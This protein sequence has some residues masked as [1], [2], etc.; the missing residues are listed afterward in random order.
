MR[1]VQN[2]GST[3]NSETSDYPSDN[4]DSSPPR[5]ILNKENL[6]QEGKQQTRKGYMQKRAIQVQQQVTIQP[7]VQV[8]Q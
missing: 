2:I 4:E 5:K 7:A 6:K 8:Q 1:V 3:S